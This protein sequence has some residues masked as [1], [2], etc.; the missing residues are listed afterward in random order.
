[1][2]QIFRLRA[3]IPDNSLFEPLDPSM[4]P[5]CSTLR[6][7]NVSWELFSEG[8]HNHC[9]RYRLSLETMADSTQPPRTESDAS[10]HGSL[11]TQPA[12]ASQPDGAR[13]PSTA[14]T[15]TSSQ[16]SESMR[17]RTR[18]IFKEIQDLQ[19]RRV[20]QRIPSWF[21]KRH[22]DKTI[23]PAPPL[24]Q[25]HLKD[26]ARAPG[27]PRRAEEYY[28]QLTRADDP[29]GPGGL[30]RRSPVVDLLQRDAMRPTGQRRLLWIPLDDRADNKYPHV[31]F[32][33][34]TSI[35]G[36]QVR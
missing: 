13:A 2:S 25:R 17:L 22:S 27:L 30:G 34:I 14:A 29:R 12:S 7:D 31:R 10:S 32:W 16:S 3:C 4:K 21:G 20:P 6:L 9:L 15:H 26:R 23:R 8:F 36:G 18:Q 19:A 1:M 24:L 5:C 33:E 11:Q 28:E 35:D